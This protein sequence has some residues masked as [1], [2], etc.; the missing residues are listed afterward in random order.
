MLALLVALS[1]WGFAATGG[2]FVLGKDN[3]A[4]APTRLTSSARH[5]PTLALKNTGRQAAA[6]FSVRPGVAPF[7]VGSTAKVGKLNA[8]LVDGVDSTGFYAAGSKVTDAD[9]LDGVDST[10]FYRSGSK[11]ADSDRLDGLDSTALQ[12]RV[13]GT[14]A[15]G[16]YVRSVNVDGTVVCE[17]FSSRVEIVRG[18]EATL[19]G[20]QPPTSGPV[21]GRPARLEKPPSVEA[22]KR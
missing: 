8:D 22:G 19:A 2:S 13:G 4:E 18:T 9:R 6:T 11:V 1:G 14:C 20:V 5:G 16:S 21:R 17:A 7:S 15:A 10:G 12:K 3:K